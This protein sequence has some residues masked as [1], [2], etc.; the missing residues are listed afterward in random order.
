MTKKR[1]SDFTCEVCGMPA[2]ASF[3]DV[4]EIPSRDG[5]YRLYTRDGPLNYRCAEHPGK[6]KITE[7]RRKWSD[8]MIPSD[9]SQQAIFTVEFPDGRAYTGKAIATSLSIATSPLD[10]TEIGDD[11]HSYISGSQ[12]WT[13]EL[14]GVG[15]LLA[16]QGLDETI[17]RDSNAT[18]WEC[19]YCG[20]SWSRSQHKC[21]DG[22]NGCGAQRPAMW[23]I[24]GDE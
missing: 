15:N 1:F 11:Y 14:Q 4:R 12:T 8:E 22:V 17:N 18:H 7:L 3:C 19:P 13:I 6:G 10:I 16:V 9:L 20:R 5:I 2:S 21:W 23:W 24:K